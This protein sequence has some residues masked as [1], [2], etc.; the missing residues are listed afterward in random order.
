MSK[1]PDGLPGHSSRF[2]VDFQNLTYRFQTPGI[3][4]C[5]HSLD[6]PGDIFEA[7]LP[8]EKGR[9]GDFVGSVQCNSFPTTSLHRFIRQPQTREFFHVRGNEIQMP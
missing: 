5:D 9:Y 7:D 2:L 1:S 4:C 8:G 6:H 3:R